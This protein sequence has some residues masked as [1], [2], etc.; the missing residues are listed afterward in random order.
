VNNAE[1]S[2]SAGISDPD[3]SRLWSRATKNSV[4]VSRISSV[5]IIATLSVGAAA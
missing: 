1:G 2:C 5:V 4:K 3:G